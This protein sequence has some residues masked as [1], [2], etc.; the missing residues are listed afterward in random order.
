VEA[1]DNNT[2]SVD[3]YFTLVPKLW[4]LRDDFGASEAEKLFYYENQDYV[5]VKGEQ[6]YATLLK[7]PRNGT[8]ALVSNLSRS[9]QELIVSFNLDRLGLSPA[10]IR[11]VDPLSGKDVPITSDG[12][13]TLLLGS[14]EWKYLWLKP[15][16][17]E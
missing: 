8:L 14:E 12:K 3:P 7:H 10:A 5:T 9:N 6:G 13:V 2:G 16:A 11:A 4:K 15:T 17:K 1:F